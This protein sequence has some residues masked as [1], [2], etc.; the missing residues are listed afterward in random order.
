MRLKLIACNVFMREVC[1]CV[2][3]SPHIVDIE[4]TELGEHVHSDT[5]RARLQAAIDASDRAPTAWD[6]VLLAFGICGNTTVGLRA[7]CRPLV[8]PRAH[9]CCTILLG[10]KQEFRKHFE[11]CPSTPFSSAGY[12]ERGEYYLRKEDGES[13]LYYG[14]S[15]AAMVEQYGEENAKYIWETMH[16]PRPEGANRAV[17]IE[18]PEMS[19][20]GY[21]E[22]FK[23]K[24]Q[25]EGKDVVSLPGSLE[26]LRKLVFGE[27][28]PETFLV[29][30]PGQ[31]VKGVYDWSEIVRAEDA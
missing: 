17:F 8:L 2:A 10:S 27:W 29:L 20:L 26:T 24:A 28:D 31:K 1:H 16:P 13:K 23:A 3:R 14:D 11:D 4:F 22:Q 21:A 18:V 15:Y 6:A 12:M 9:D 25:A 19:H 7:G 5:L 30:Q